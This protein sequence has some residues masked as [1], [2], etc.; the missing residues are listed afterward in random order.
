[1][2][3][4]LACPLWLKTQV[5]TFSAAKLARALSQTNEGSGVLAAGTTLARAL[6]WA[7]SNF[8][9]FD[10]VSVLNEPSVTCTEARLKMRTRKNMEA[11]LI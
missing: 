8:S 10:W 7:A 3:S 5:L 9:I 2:F 6:L 1:M 4:P 11:D